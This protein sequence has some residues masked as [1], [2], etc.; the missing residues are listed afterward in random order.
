MNH[1]D[2]RCNQVRLLETIDYTT[3]TFRVLL[4]LEEG[5][6][7]KH[8]SMVDGTTGLSYEMT[9]FVGMAN[10]KGSGGSVLNTKHAQQFVTV[11]KS[12]SL[13]V[14]TFGSTKDPLVKSVDMQLVRVKVTDFF[15]PVAYMWCLKPV[16]VFPSNFRT[17]V[18]A[19]SIVPL[20]SVRVI[21]IG[22][23]YATPADSSSWLQACASANGQYIYAD[24][25]LLTLVDHAQSQTC[26]QTDLAMCYPPSS[27][28]SVVTFGLPLPVDFITP[29]DLAAPLASQSRIEAQFVV[30]AY[31]TTAK[32]NVLTT[33]SMSVDISPLGFTAECE[34]ASASQNLA[35]VV[36]GNVYIGTAVSDYEW[37][38]LMQKKENMDVPGSTPSNSLDFATTSVQ[39]AVMTFAAL[40]NAAYFEDPRYQGQSAHM[41]DIFTVHFLEPLSGRAGDPTPNY[42][43]A[44]AL[45]L[46]GG[47]FVTKSDAATHSIW[48]EPTAALLAICPLRPTIGKLACLTRIDSTYKDSHLS[49]PDNTV[50]ELRMNDATSIAELQGLMANLLLQ[51]GSNDFTNNLGSGFYAELSSKLALNNRYRKAYVVNPVINW[52]LDAIGPHGGSTAYTVSSKI[53]GIG[54]I[55]LQSAGGQQLARR[56]LSIGLDD[57]AAPSVALRGV[58]DDGSDEDPY[59]ADDDEPKATSAGSKSRRLLQTSE[60]TLA[61]SMLQA[62]NSLVVNL[63]IPDK[64]AVT[65][66]CP[67]I[68][69]TDE[70]CRGL[71]FT[72]QVTGDHA[73]QLCAAE[74]QGTLGTILD[75]GM[76][77]ALM[78][79]S[80]FAS[81]VSQ[82]L[83]MH[84]S[85]KGCDS[86]QQGA[87]RRA[88][89]QTGR[90]VI[91][92]TDLLLSVDFGNSV[93]VNERTKQYINFFVNSTTISQLLGGSAVL[94]SLTISAPDPAQIAAA[95]NGSLPGNTYKYN[96]TI[97]YDGVNIKNNT[98]FLN[99]KNLTDYLNGIAPNSNGAVSNDYFI[100]D[101]LKPPSIDKK[102][103]GSRNT[104][105]FVALLINSLV[106]AAAGSIALG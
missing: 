98:L 65:Q 40:G 44:K 11:T 2:P 20:N 83:L 48:L 33:V 28:T 81:N 71:Q 89:K 13:T 59:M 34:T 96:M 4:V 84:Y 21:K 19:A 76:R 7:R 8:A 85:I 17:P 60:G 26:V 53:I 23:G 73:D 99:N 70:T 54:M 50:V 75:A 6:L 63:N 27:A 36:S 95:N 35:D 62:S 102:S 94:T 92:L 57:A 25:A 103:S 39:G 18:G 45:F 14:S 90:L 97:V 5:D 46:A 91:V 10:F 87:P 32:S 55:T 30:Q 56:L 38:S 67:V 93:V 80:N 1:A 101:A 52:R 41:R 31:D 16:F 106:L 82:V 77:S 24:P 79:D 9:F 86:T 3:R 69:A 105:A 66:L 42:D 49:R 72:D 104:A 29:A 78:R 64:T 37:N 61:P 68:G 43:A 74:A 51:G 88:L 12:N 47:A 22:A 58:W 15:N 100:L